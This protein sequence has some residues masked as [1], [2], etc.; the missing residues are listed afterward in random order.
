MRVLEVD[1]WTSTGNVEE[2][3]MKDFDINGVEGGDAKAARE[4]FGGHAK[5]LEVHEESRPRCGYVWFITGEDGKLKFW[6]GSYD[7]SD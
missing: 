4:I 3:T 6:K 5:I 7:S 1:Q 2:H